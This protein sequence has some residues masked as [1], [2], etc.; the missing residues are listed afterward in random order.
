MKKKQVSK[1]LLS[2]TFKLKQTIEFNNGILRVRLIFIKIENEQK[3]QSS[4]TILMNEKKKHRAKSSSN[5]NEIKTWWKVVMA[6]SFWRY[7]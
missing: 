5:K 6:M 2:L 3:L 1:S 7:P 4:V